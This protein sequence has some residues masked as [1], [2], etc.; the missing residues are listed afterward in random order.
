MKLSVRGGDRGIGPPRQKAEI[1]TSH[2]AQWRRQGCEGGRE[3][4]RRHRPGRRQGDPPGFAL[5]RSAA[6][7]HGRASTKC[8]MQT[9]GL[10]REGQISNSIVWSGIFCLCVI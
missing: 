7:A 8:W 4:V 2:A 6:A 3:P 10:P 1:T 9:H 5:A